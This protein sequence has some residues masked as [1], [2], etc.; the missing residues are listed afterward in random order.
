M[1]DLHELPRLRDSLS[2]LYLEHVVVH[3]KHKA[4]EF[5]NEDGRTMIPIAALCVLLLGPGTSI[6]HAAIKALAEDG[7]SVLWVG[8]DATRFYAQ[9]MGE[10]RK[11][12]H[13][14]RQAELSSDPAMRK[15]V[16]MRM[17]CKR[18]GDQLD[19]RLTLPQ[20]RG[21]E[22]ARVR[23]TYSETGKKYGVA[24]HGR[25]YDQ[26]NWRF[27]DPVNRA[28]SA[29]N[30]LLNGICHAAIVSGGYSPAIGFIHTG[31]QLSFVYDIADLYKTEFTIP[32]AFKTAAESGVGVEAR[33]RTACRAAFHKAN[34]L[35]RILPD[36][37]GLLQLGAP[38]MKDGTDADGETSG[39]APL[40]QDLFSS[41]E[42]QNL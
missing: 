30:A 25:R 38:A 15:K 19:S 5:I 10:T 4:V 16:V 12:Y 18:F 41:S 9:G 36:V 13:V 2:Y 26:R 40:W 28:L 35:G 11:A 29:A 8:E 3:K 6:T 14:L 32:L 34:L 23:K 42:E 20:I 27:G 7:C 24:W 17:Y 37:D 1:R 21:H 39:T 33:V 31:R 22:G